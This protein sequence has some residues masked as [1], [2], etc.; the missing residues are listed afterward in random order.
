MLQMGMLLILNTLLDILITF[1]LHGRLVIIHLKD[2]CS[3]R[4]VIEVSTI[5]IIMVLKHYNL[6]ITKLVI[7]KED[8]IKKMLI[9]DVPQECVVSS[10]MF[11]YK[12]LDRSHI[13]EKGIP[14]EVFI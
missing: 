2:T 13:N 12:L 4:C 11:K 14:L 1:M 3:D 6:L 8:I 10:S 5:D 7:M 9:K